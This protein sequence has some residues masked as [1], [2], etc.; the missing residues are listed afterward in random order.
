MKDRIHKIILNEGLTPSKLADIMQVQRSSVSHI[1]AGRNKPSMD[2]LTKL[3]H[4]FPSISGHW[5]LT[6]LGQMY[7]DGKEPVPDSPK[8]METSSD[9]LFNSSDAPTLKKEAPAAEQSAMPRKEI[10]QRDIPH[11][12]DAS[13]KIIK[14]IIVIYDDYSTE[15]IFNG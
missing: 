5:L 1:L 8:I 12:A 4:S 9:G 11:K 14:K 2:F 15:E 6:G 7:S 3:I 13:K 10:S